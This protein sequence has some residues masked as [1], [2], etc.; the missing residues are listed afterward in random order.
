[1][2]DSLMSDNLKREKALKRRLKKK[3]MIML[4][5]TLFSEQYDS[6]QVDSITDIMIPMETVKDYIRDKVGINYTSEPWIINQIRKYEEEI[7]T[8]LF[9]KIVTEQGSTLGLC[10]DLSTYEQKRHLYV[11]QK[12]KTANGVFDLI[13]NMLEKSVS[14]KTI[15]ILLDGGSTVTRVAEIIAKNPNQPAVNWEIYTHN[16]G[17]IECFGKTSTAYQGISIHVPQ[18]IYDHVTNLIL[19][20][21][22]EFYLERKFDW[23]IQG[24][25]F[26]SSGKLYVE[27]SEE[28]RVKAS[29]LSDCIGKKV[30]V[31]TGHE[32]TSNLS[33]F[34]EPFGVVSQY[35]YVVYPLLASGSTAAEKMGNELMQFAK[36]MPIMIQNWSYVIMAHI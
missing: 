2:P 25:S 30:L 31:L 33:C 27:K 17:V 34:A 12:I 1:M 15:K 11:T 35:D 8:R 14:Y 7:G 19:S 4:L 20:D 6:A 32:A 13:F 18:G 22:L 3:D 29:I 10:Q 9:R 5:L 23:I 28:A 26:L 36:I 24:T 16:L 21:R